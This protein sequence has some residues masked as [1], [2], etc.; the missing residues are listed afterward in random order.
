[1]RRGLR[2]FKDPAEVLGALGALGMSVSFGA[3]IFGDGDP[4]LFWLPAFAIAV[5]G[6][7]GELIWKY[8][9]RRA[10]ATSNDEV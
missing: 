8:R 7:A 1:M 4:S 10:D 5:L 2:N 9:R 3:L 6:F